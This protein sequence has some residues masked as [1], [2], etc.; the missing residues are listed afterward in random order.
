MNLDAGESV[1]RDLAKV[2]EA[3][4]VNADSHE[5]LGYFLRMTAVT[6]WTSGRAQL[7]KFGVSAF[8]SWATF[9]AWS[10][11]RA[12]SFGKRRELAIPQNRQVARATMKTDRIFPEP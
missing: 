5:K 2:M 12:T 8:V 9:G 4:C 11:S 3:T 6:S 1:A 7:A 10:S